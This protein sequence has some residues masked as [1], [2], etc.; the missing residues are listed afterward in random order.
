M[1][2]SGISLSRAARAGR[3]RTCAAAGV[4]DAGQEAGEV[5]EEVA[6]GLLRA[7]LE[8]HGGRLHD[9]PLRQGRLCLCSAPWGPGQNLRL[10]TA[11]L[12]AGSEMRRPVTGMCCE[13]VTT[14]L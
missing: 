8:R 10:A 6:R 4:S 2:R 9:D 1:S 5:A 12:R 3:T 14:H 13:N 11:T 7:Q